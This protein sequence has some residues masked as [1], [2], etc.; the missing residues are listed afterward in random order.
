LPMSRST[1]KLFNVH[2]KTGLLVTSIILILFLCWRD[3]FGYFFTAKDSFTLIETSRIQSTKDIARIFSE[4]LMNNTKFINKYKYYR[5][6]A[7]L[8]YSMDYAIWKLNP[9]GYHL[10]DFLLHLLVTILIFFF[11]RLLLNGEQFVAW[12]SA[13][14]FAIHPTLVEVGPATARRHDILAALFILGSLILVMKQNFSTFHNKSLGFLS[15][16]FYAFA[17]GAKEIA[18]ILP[19]LVWSLNYFS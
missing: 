3:I 5:P 6:I 7:C 13:V 2:I 19:M 17:L 12:L 14:V 9:F 18:I 8:S 10:T 4:P 1:T 16:L 15:V 11:I